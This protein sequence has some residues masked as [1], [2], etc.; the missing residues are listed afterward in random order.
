MRQRLPLD[1]EA[2]RLGETLPL[3][4]FMAELAAPSGGDGVVA[5]AAV[6]LG[7]PPGA[8]DVTA[9]LEP[10]KRRVERSLIDVEASSGHLLNAGAN[11]PAVHRLE[12]QGLEDQEID[13]AA[14]RIRFGGA[15]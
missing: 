1:D 9:M 8:F 10:L 11:A 5:G 2:D 14:Q 12:R 6:V 7:R 15:V 13:A 4:D 3:V